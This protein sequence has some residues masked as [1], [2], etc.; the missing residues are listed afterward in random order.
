MT[1]G[2]RERVTSS[3]S[4]TAVKGVSYD[5]DPSSEHATAS[6]VDPA[7][8]ARVSVLEQQIEEMRNEM[9]KAQKAGG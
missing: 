1:L 2:M 8:A 7:H 4:S 3:S 6:T 5:G 9:Q